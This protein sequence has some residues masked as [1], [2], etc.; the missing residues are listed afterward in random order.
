VGEPGDHLIGENPDDHI[1]RTKGGAT[2]HE[3]ETGTGAGCDQQDD[4]YE[5]PDRDG[6]S[7]PP[8]EDQTDEEHRRDHDDSL[9][10]RDERPRPPLQLRDPFIRTPAQFPV[11]RFDLDTRGR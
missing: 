5:S 2:Q 10:R 3:R 11:A 9:A 7:P 4:P 6:Y 1:G 8:P